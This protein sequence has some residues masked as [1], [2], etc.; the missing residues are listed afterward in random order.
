MHRPKSLMMSLPPSIANSLTWQPICIHTH[1]S[2]FKFRAL[3]DISWICLL[4][5][6]NNKI[7]MGFLTYKTWFPKQ[8]S[9]KVLLLC[10]VTQQVAGCD[11]TGN[12]NKCL[13]HKLA[14]H[15]GEFIRTQVHIFSHYLQGFSS[16]NSPPP[17]AQLPFHL[18][19][20]SLHIILYML[21]RNS[22]RVTLQWERLH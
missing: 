19:D 12:E 8:Q 20:S 21:T 4:C 14:D 7:N 10:I 15:H 9:W 3:R 22:P 16:S 2:A 17:T 5:N 6:N 18:P 1:T 13:P 11:E